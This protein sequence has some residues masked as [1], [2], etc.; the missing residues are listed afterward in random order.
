M[1]MPAPPRHGSCQ[2]NSSAKLVSASRVNF[3]DDVRH[4]LTIAAWGL[5]VGSDVATQEPLW[6]LSFGGET[7]ETFVARP[8]D[9]AVQSPV[10]ILPDR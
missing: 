4:D 1:Q 5:Q 8:A 10:R 9:E 2:R 6:E 7:V 3:I